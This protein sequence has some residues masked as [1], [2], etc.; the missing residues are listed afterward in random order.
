MS[1][2][3]IVRFTELQAFA[4]KCKCKLEVVDEYTFGGVP[5]FHGSKYGIGPTSIR[6][7]NKHLGSKEGEDCKVFTYKSLDEVKS[8]LNG[9][10]SCI[11]LMAKV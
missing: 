11:K 7:F 3:V 10:D 9:V 8:H 5:A 2:H 4:R 1:A 6:D